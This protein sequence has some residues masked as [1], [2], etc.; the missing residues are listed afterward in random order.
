MF[1]WLRDRVGS[2][3]DEEYDVDRDAAVGAFESLLDDEDVTVDGDHTA[4]VEQFDRIVARYDEISDEVDEA[5]GEL[6]EDGEMPGIYFA[7][8][9]T[10]LDRWQR[11]N[12]ALV[13][14]IESLHDSL[15]ELTG[16]L[17]IDES[18]VDEDRPMPVLDEFYQELQ[19]AYW[20]T[21]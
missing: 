11:E 10:R 12:P 9:N 14:E 21:Q 8:D 17:E 1:D 16:R 15:S 7:K 13:G 2:T 20:L 3:G 18:S 6:T 5:M 4:V 19:S